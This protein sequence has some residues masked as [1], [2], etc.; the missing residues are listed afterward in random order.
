MTRDRRRKVEVRAHQAATGTPYLV[1]RRQITSPTLVEVMQQH[2]LLSRFGIGVYDPLRKTTEQRKAELAADRERLAED[3]AMVMET[4]AWLRENIT[5]IKTPT[6]SSYYVKHVM[7]RTTR[8]YVANGVFI[9]AALIAGY[10]F[11]Y[12]Q[13]NVLFGMSR[14]DLKRMN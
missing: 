2:P 5:P 1:A 3:E 7:E 12:E 9:A 13:P 4:T 10:P 8:T 11:K 14:R 6:A